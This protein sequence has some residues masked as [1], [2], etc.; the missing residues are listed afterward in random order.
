MD[1]TGPL[2]TLGYLAS[3]P[4]SAA[5]N[6]Y[7]VTPSINLS[8][9]GS[10]VG[11][12]AL[13]N[14]AVQSATVVGGGTGC[15]V[16]SAITLTLSGGT[17][18]TAAQV[19]GTTNSSGVLAGALTVT[20]AGSYVPGTATSALVALTAVPT[21]SGSTCA[22]YPTVLPAWGIGSINVAGAGMNVPLTGVTAPQRADWIS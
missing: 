16:S 12:V 1:G 3:I 18:G 6:A 20:V 10:A 9:L 14:M 4:V 8:G 5:G 17:L 22:T 11:V 2:R 7:V 19:S 15:P 13:A 21:A